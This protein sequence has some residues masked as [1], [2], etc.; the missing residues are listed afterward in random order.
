MP[1][2]GRPVLGVDI[3]PHE[4][5]VVEMRGNWSHA[6][7]VNVGAIPTPAGAMEGDRVANPDAVAEA[8]RQ[9]LHDRGIGARDAIMGIAARS[10]ITRVIDVPR[11]PDKE[12]RTVIE[13]EMAHYQILR[14]GTGTFDFIRLP[15]TE[16]NGEATPQ[17]LLMAVED[18]IVSG[19]CEVADRAGLRLIALEPVLLSM[20]RAAFAQDQSRPT[21]ACLSITYGKSEIAIMDES[22]LRLYRRVDTGSDDLISSRRQTN[23]VQQATGRALLGSLPE[24]EI[25]LGEVPSQSDINISAANNLAIELQR[26]IEYYRR[27][28]PNSE[29]INRVLVA[30]NDPELQPIVAWLSE[31]LGTEM[32]TV[33]PQAS[34]IL[35]PDVDALLAPPDGLRFLG[36]AGLAMHELAGH[37]TT[38]PLF[39]LSSLQQASNL[40]ETSKRK[41]VIAMV[42]A[43][44]ILVIGLGAAFAVGQR[45]DAVYNDLTSAQKQLA[46]KQQEHQT[47][48]AQLEAQQEQLRV[49]KTQ[50][51][52]FPR[53]VDAAAAAVDPDAGL[54][55]VNLDVSG[56]VMLNGDAASSRAVNNT[57]QNLL[58]C[59]YFS[60]PMLESFD[61]GGPGPGGGTVRFQIS[62]QLA[63]FLRAGP[64]PPGQPGQSGQ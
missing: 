19:Y 5:R 22:L 9:L 12:M 29:P 49:L 28:Y 31:A 60:N 17:V 23:P 34:M 11:V 18:L 38:L 62:S 8:L 16:E 6:E 47:Q 53:I 25:D 10:I 27:E 52:P 63:G 30:T 50:G 2:K 33:S 7:V 14:E 64:P 58:S 13:G 37:P 24:Q 41:L 54:T 56:K 55:D 59:P 39:D 51:F 3:H 36:A 32:V 15:E 61:S 45:A 20:F 40:I 48:V 57:L 4:I 46:A 35:D 43:A 44:A 1:A 21:V 42:A 26:S